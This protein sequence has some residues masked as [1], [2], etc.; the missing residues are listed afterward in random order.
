M[1]QKYS[2]MFRVANKVEPQ[3]DATISSSNM[4]P[5]KWVWWEQSSYKDEDEPEYQIITQT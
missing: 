2:K 5:V 4:K 1:K 3:S